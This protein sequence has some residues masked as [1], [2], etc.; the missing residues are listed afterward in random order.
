MGK[1]DFT[2]IPHGVSGVQD[3][4]SVV[5]ERGVVGL[6]PCLPCAEDLSKAQAWGGTLGSSGGR[7]LT[8]WTCRKGISK[9]GGQA[10]LT[11]SVSPKG[12]AKNPIVVQPTRVDVSADL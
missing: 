7:E 1:E 5:W 2:K 11:I 9:S 10:D 4:M 12:K 3:R 6:Q 8:E